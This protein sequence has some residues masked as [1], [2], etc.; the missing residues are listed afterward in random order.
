MEIRLEIEGTQPLLCHNIEMADPDNEFTKQIS[1][2]SSKRKKTEEDR[3]AIERL[4]WFG[5][6]Y[7]DPTILGPVIP[8]RM[9]RKSIIEA[10][11][12][13]KLGKAVTRALTFKNVHVPLVYDGPKDLEELFQLKK[14]HNRASVSI[15]RAKVMRVRPSFPDWKVVADAILI[16]EALDLE[17]LER[18]VSL[19]GQVEG[20]G[21]NRVNGYGRYK[22]TVKVLEGVK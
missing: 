16:E 9:L 2:I 10:A 21:D 7:T 18:L 1:L 19:A 11:K 8:T 12:I 5:G 22:A 17:D 20:I 13:N 15:G 4:E 14:Y 6:L 3:R